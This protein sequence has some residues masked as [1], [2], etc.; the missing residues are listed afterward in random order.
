MIFLLVILLVTI[1]GAGIIMA[2]VANN[3][4][5]KGF[6]SSIFVYA[7]LGSI[8]CLVSVIPILIALVIRIQNEQTGKIDELL[9]LFEPSRFPKSNY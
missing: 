6:P 4:R 8:S 3:F 5:R 2:I 9:A 1:L 7:L